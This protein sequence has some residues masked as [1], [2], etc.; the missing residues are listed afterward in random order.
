MITIPD[1]NAV[2]TMTF[3]VGDLVRILG[4]VSEGD[5]PVI[6]GKAREADYISDNLLVPTGKSD[7][8]LELLP[9]SSKTGLKGLI[10]QSPSGIQYK[11]TVS[12]SGALR[13][14]PV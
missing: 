8:F 12:D 11:L 7:V 5:N 6:Y 2:S 10:M 1:L 13:I 9:N 4:S 3:K 14:N